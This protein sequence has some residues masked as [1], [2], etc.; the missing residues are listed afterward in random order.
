MD[1]YEVALIF[2]TEV[3]IKKFNPICPW[4]CEKAIPN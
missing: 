2:F 1:D 4:K 3:L